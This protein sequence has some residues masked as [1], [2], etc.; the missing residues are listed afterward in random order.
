MTEAPLTTSNGILRFLYDFNHAAI[1]RNVGDLTHEESLIAPPKAGNCANWVLGHIVTNR[2]FILE[3][4]NEQPLW[5]EADGDIYAR[6]SKPLD[7]ALARPFESLLADFE[8]TQ[9]RLRRGL[10]NLDPELLDLK[11]KEGATRPRGAQLHFLH[12]HEAYHAG[13]LGLL[14]RMAGKPGAI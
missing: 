4:V 10:E 2:A 13:Q 7:P 12:F 14:R 6:Q 3:L 9:E 8:Q 11:H 5:G 1:T